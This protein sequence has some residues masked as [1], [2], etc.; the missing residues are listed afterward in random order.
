MYIDIGFHD[1]NHSVYKETNI[2]IVDKPVAIRPIQV[3]CEI[4]L[5]T[6][7]GT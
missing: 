4:A 5:K 1:N 7:R 3:F 6:I 2:E